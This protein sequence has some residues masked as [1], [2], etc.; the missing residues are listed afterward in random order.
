MKNLSGV[1]LYPIYVPS[2]IEF[3]IDEII[4]GNTQLG[5][6]VSIRTNATT[7][8]INANLVNANRFFLIAYI[9]SA[10]LPIFTL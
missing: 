3:Q 5:E 2:F 8:I 9:I 4:K 7:A 6:G 10:V 1:R